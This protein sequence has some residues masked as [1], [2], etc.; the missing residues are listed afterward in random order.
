MSLKKK[1]A[2]FAEEMSNNAPQE[3]LETMGAEISELVSKQ[4]SRHALKA[5][6]RAPNFSLQDS[7]GNIIELNEV[8]RRGPVFLSFNRG[9]WCPFCSLEFKALQ[10]S[11][12]EVEKKSGTILVISP[13]LPEKSQKL[14]QENGITY[15]IL[16][17]EANKVAEQYGLVFTLP[18]V[19]RPIHEDFGMDIPA[20]NGDQ[21]YRLPYP[22]TLAINTNGII[23]YSFINANWMDRA[24]PSEVIA[25]L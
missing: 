23:T 11:V 5:G 24:E 3:V 22:A 15:P 13:Q 16:F 17:D 20:H 12:N 19:L 25:A 7:T 4:Q 1:L 14:Q 6:D 9:N 21:S 10:E 8:L 18:E 2:A